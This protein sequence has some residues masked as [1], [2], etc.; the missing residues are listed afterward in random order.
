MTT[1][2]LTFSTEH[3]QRISYTLLK[4]GITPN[5]LSNRMSKISLPDFFKYYS[6]T[7]EQKE[8]IVLLE[9]QMPHTLLQ[10]DSSWVIKYREQPEVPPSVVP[11]QCLDIIA[12]FEGFRPTPYLCPAGVPT[13]GYGNTFYEDGR[14]VQMSD[15]AI[16]EPQAKRMLSSIVEKDFWDV[17]KTT[18]PF[19]SEMNDNQRSALT[20]FGFNLGAHF[21]G[22]IGFNTI[23]AVLRDK[24]WNE[25]PGAFLLYV[26]P[27]SPYEA[28]LRRRRA[29]EGALWNA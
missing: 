26:N 15:P 10:D 17:L 27:G 25:V 20:S 6:G 9:S 12:E 11:P 5:L 28:G 19:W 29:A 7:V 14:K 22:N 4:L 8:A 23:S 1:G 21:F 24:A 16:T 2:H 18:I 13:I 3:A